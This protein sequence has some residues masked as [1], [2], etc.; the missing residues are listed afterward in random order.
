[1]LAIGRVIFGLP[2]AGVLLST[3]AMCALCYWM[4]RGWTTPGWALLGG[5]LAVMEFGPLSPWMNGYW[6]GSVAAIGG[7]LVFG[8]LPRLRGGGRARYAGAPGVGDWGSLAY[9]SV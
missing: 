7:C 3:A 2:W 5:V 1:M 4:L 9:S 8:A 6:G